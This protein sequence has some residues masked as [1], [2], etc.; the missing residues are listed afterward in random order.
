MGGR[1]GR[2][3]KRGIKWMGGKQGRKGKE[4][5]SERGGEGDKIDSMNTKAL[6]Y[7]HHVPHALFDYLCGSL[8]CSLNGSR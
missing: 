2:R 1:D 8:H 5:G 7:L 6:P 4:G 3:G